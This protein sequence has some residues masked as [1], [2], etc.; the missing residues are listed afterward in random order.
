LFLY[1][2]SVRKNRV[3]LSQLELNNLSKELRDWMHGS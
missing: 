1:I 2:S 3:G